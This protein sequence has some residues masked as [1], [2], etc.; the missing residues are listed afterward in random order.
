MSFGRL[1]AFLFCTLL[2][3]PDL[4][5][6]TPIPF[7]YRD[8]LIWL[9]VAVTGK[10]EP[11]NFVLDSGAGSSV[12]DLATARRLG[13]KL[14]QPETVRGVGGLALACRARGLNARWANVQLPPSLLVVDLSG[15]GRSCH[16][17]ID[18]LLGADFFREH[19]VQIDYAA[20]TIR[21]LQRRELNFPRGDTLPLVNRND[22]FCLRVCV[23]GTA[24]QLLRLDT[25]C[26]TALEWVVSTQ[27]AKKFASNAS[28]LNPN[29][30][31]QF[32]TDLQLGSKYLAGIK[33]GLHTTQMFDGE[34]GLIGDDLLSRFTVTI[35][36]AGQRCMITD[37]K[38]LSRL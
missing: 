22:T 2:A 36:A 23:G 1:I 38:G 12:L 6:A 7:I 17:R 18:G 27:E 13:V 19:I 24:P 9:K 29:S 25:G 5:A 15:P 8:G 33:T 35:D 31:R 20:Q 10:D 4:S 16:Q 34:S 11:L 21:L 30:P 3:A 26:T 37:P 28:G 14:D 32:H